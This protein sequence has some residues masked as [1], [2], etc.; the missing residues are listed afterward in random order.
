MRHLFQVGLVAAFV[1]AT[2]ST[3]A[4]QFSEIPSALSITKSSNKNQVN[5]SVAV[6]DACTPS[7]ASPVHA[8]WRMLE[9]G[10]DATEGLSGGEERAFGI[11]RQNV[12]RDSVRVTLRALPARPITIHTARGSGQCVATA[13]T[14]INGVSARISSVFVKIKLFGVDYVQLTGVA[15]D[16][17]IVKEKLSI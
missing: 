8:Y 14:T 16:G 15:D 6:D 2:P 7:G 11:E 12:D 5:Y 10:P 1:L 13:S 4:A 17:S 3:Q 9:K